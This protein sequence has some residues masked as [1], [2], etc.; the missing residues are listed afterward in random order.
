MAVRR[1]RVT[2][3]PGSRRR[4]AYSPSP[5]CAARP[6]CCI[7]PAHPHR[8]S[9]S[10]PG[11]FMFDRV[12]ILSASAGAGHIRAAQALERA[13]HDLG[14]AREVLHVDALEYT[15]LVYRQICSQ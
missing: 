5:A 7:N 9:E 3:G 12:L 2:T 15:T 6:L 1:F 8:H 4:A 11:A 13:F 10:T 14:A